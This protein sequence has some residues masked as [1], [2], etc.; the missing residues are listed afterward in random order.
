MHKS[1]ATLQGP[2]PPHHETQAY[3]QQLFGAP[4]ADLDISLSSRFLD[5]GGN[6]GHPQWRLV[7]LLAI[8]TSPTKSLRTEGIHRALIMAI[9]Y[10]Q[11][12][13][14]EAKRQKGKLKRA[15][16]PVSRKG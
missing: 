9:P 10:C 1:H 14:D 12:N 6:R 13:A 5:D 7:C 15:G 3:L 16:W 4:G 11:A 8:W 2:F